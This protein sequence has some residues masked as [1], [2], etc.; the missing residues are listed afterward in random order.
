MSDNEINLVE[1]FWDNLCNAAKE[2]NW[3]P[4]DYCSND[5]VSDCCCFLRNGDG[6]E[7]IRALVTILKEAGDTIES[8]HKNTGIDLGT[9]SRMPFYEDTMKK[10]DDVLRTTKDK[11]NF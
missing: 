10:I 1:I 3:I 11:Y 8:Y 6:S 5:W 4:G 7:D 9:A 2:S